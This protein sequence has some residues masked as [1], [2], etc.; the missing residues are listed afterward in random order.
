MN[1]KT[2]SHSLKNKFFTV[3]KG[4]HVSGDDEVNTVTKADSLISKRLTI[5]KAFGSVY[6]TGF[7]STLS[8]KS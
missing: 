1:W 7:L 4:R 2:N 8:P 3:T 5:S 6:Q